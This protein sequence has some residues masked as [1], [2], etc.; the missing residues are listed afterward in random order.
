MEANCKTII[1]CND[2]YPFQQ[3]RSCHP[4]FKLLLKT[5][6]QFCLKLKKFNRREALCL[7]TKKQCFNHSLHIEHLKNKGSLFVAHKQIIACYVPTS[8][9]LFF[10]A[11]LSV[12]HKCAI[13]S[14]QVCTYVHV[15][16]YQRSL[17]CGTLLGMS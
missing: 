13:G 15:R 1:R 17:T 4:Q 5:N 2:P 11:T 8:V 12:T 6:F 7:E 9:F 14:L 3:L 16:R 10:H